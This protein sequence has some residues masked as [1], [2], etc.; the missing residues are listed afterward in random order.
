MEDVDVLQ[1]ALLH[2]TVEDTDTSPQELQDTFGQRVAGLVAEVG[3]LVKAAGELGIK[4][5]GI[6]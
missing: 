2:D 3:V 5:G 6:P 1:A 4:L